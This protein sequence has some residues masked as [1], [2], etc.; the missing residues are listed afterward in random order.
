MKR[1][2][3]W[4]LTLAMVLMGTMTFG[5]ALAEEEPITVVFICPHSGT[6]S[7]AE[8]YKMVQDY[9]LQETGVLVESIR[10][11][12]T[13]DTDKINMMLSSGEQ[14]DVFWGDWMTYSEMGAVQP[15]NDYM[16]CIPNVIRVWTEFN[17][18]AFQ[19]YTDKDGKIWGFPRNVNRVFYQT[20]VRQDWLDELGM[21]GPTNL[22][23]LNEY[24]YVVKDLDPYGNGETIPMIVRGSSLETLCYHFLGGFT[25][26]GYSNWQDEDGSIK[27]YFLQ[28]GYI[29]FLKQCAQ[30]YTDGVIHKENFSWDVNTVQQYI[31]SGRVAC[32]GAYSTDT[33]A[34]YTNLKANYPG[35]SWYDYVEGMTGPNGN[36][37]ESMIKA[38]SVCGMI[39]ATSDEEHIRAA[40]KVIDWMYADWENF[41]VGYSG[42]RGVHWDY[43]Y[44]Y[45]NAEEL[46]I[47]KNLEATSS[48]NSNFWFGI[49]LPMEKDCVT[50]DPDGQRNMHNEYM[51]HQGNISAAILPF[52]LNINYNTTEINE[53]CM[54]YADIQT[55]L[56]EEQI[57]FVMG[58]R[59]LGEWDQ[60][61]D[62]LYDMG[63]QD[64][65]DELTRQYNLAVGA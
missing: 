12:G 13:N 7:D 28:N 63:L 36:K 18:D 52:D 58:A 23:E 38:N 30:W 27:P 46:H 29:D 49:G 15:I 16:D 10:L 57:K 62:E 33:T 11:S 42:I 50:Y 35:A 61:I 20:F 64:Y 5:L 24:L 26:F 51:G 19:V 37:M 25:D 43:D 9:I 31:A 6:D 40:L 48:Y 3:A 4:V 17:E 65:I 2:F 22:D 54:G 14:L 44:S 39:N 34:Q 1:L 47:T 8:A 32:S 55:A 56:N 59:D 45:E 21:E 53:N 60:F 41:K